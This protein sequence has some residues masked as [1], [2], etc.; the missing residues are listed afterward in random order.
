MGSGGQMVMEHRTGVF[1][2]FL[3]PVLR[4]MATP[5]Y[6]TWL[7]YL[8]P[9][10]PLEQAK[11][12]LTAW[13]PSTFEVPESLRTQPGIVRD[14]AEET[15]VF[16]EKGPLRQWTVEYREANTLI[17]R[18]IWRSM[19]P[20]APRF[21]RGL[22]KLNKA[23]RRQPR[24]ARS[25][26][27][28]HELT[29]AMKELSLALGMSAVG[30]ADMDR[31]YVSK[32]YQDQD[33]GH[34]VVVFVAERSFS[35]VQTSPSVAFEQASTHT[36]GS[37]MMRVAKVARFLQDNGYRAIPLPVDG[38]I[39]IHPFAVEAGLGQLGLNG[40]LLTPIAGPRISLCAMGTDAP[41]VSDH[42]VDYGV[43]KL[44]DKCQVCA[45][46]CPVDAIPRKREYYRGV[47]KA[48][49][50]MD[51]CLPVVAKVHGCGICMKVC[52]AQRYGLAAMA[53]YYEKTGK[54]LGKGSEELEGYDWIDS[55]HYGPWNKPPLPD[56]AFFTDIPGPEPSLQLESELS[57][58]GT[59]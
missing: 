48:K 56:P 34:K 36:H 8:P 3:E 41:L 38:G 46:R 16:E 29:T 30:V 33:L 53:D 35:A 32:E 57:R 47:L 44:C 58:S 20:T 59:S 37:L 9:F 25:K 52:P 24:S 23:A 19:V 54:I 18:N 39:L 10:W 51:K 15:R 43:P 14:G 49:L 1:M 7:S 6:V 12:P 50:R 13:P 5:P 4:R 2:R 22:R 28:E 42:P 17:Q 21:A 11:P 26:L 45:K 40:Q 31:R 27:S 55:E